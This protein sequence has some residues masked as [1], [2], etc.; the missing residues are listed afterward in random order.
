MFIYI[1][2]IQDNCQF[3]V[4]YSQSDLDRDDAGDECDNCPN[5]YN[6]DQK[7]TDGDGDGDKCDNDDDN[8]GSYMITIT[9]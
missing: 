4:N 9:S 8:D 1:L 5:V 7:D 2:I 6:P 3:V